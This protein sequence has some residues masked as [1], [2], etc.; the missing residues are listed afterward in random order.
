MKINYI[1][2]EEENL[3]DNNMGTIFMDISIEIY[4]KLKFFQIK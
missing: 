1:I 3:D 2:I 4:F